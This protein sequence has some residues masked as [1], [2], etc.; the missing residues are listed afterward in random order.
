MIHG[1]WCCQG[2]YK[3]LWYY[4]ECRRIVFH[5]HQINTT[6][7]LQIPSIIRLILE[8]SCHCVVQHTQ[9]ANV[10]SKTTHQSAVKCH[11]M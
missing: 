1:S 11:A 7:C 6:L 5:L 8:M 2:S 10:V 4:F 9:A 3:L